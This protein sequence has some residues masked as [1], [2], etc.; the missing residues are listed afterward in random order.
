MEVKKKGKKRKEKKKTV[1]ELMGNS[2]YGGTFSNARMV[3]RVGNDIF[4]DERQSILKNHA[5]P[6]ITRETFVDQ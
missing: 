2:F 4:A 3:K 1:L 5:F 6:L